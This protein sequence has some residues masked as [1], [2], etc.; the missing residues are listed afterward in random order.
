[1]FPQTVCRLVKGIE[2][3][4][5]GQTFTFSLNSGILWCVWACSDG[6]PAGRGPQVAV[7]GCKRIQGAP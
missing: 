5:D 2:I 3:G 4:M 1:M 7:H 6:H